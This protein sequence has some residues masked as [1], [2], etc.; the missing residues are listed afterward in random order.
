MKNERLVDAKYFEPGHVELFCR[1]DVWSVEAFGYVADKKDDS[2]GTLV[3][4]GVECKNET[5]ARTMFEKVQSYDDI[6]S[7]LKANRRNRKYFA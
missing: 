5:D 1:Y 7:I 3:S 4:G 6:E 2:L